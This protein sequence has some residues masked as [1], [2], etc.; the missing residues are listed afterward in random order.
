MK[1]IIALVLTLVMVASMA[2]VVSFAE[3]TAEELEVSAK[4]DHIE[5]WPATNGKTWFI[6]GISS[7]NNTA[8]FKLL[9]DGDGVLRIKITAENGTTYCIPHYFFDT[10]GREFGDN[11]TFLRIAVC[12]Y[13]IPVTVGAKYSVYLDVVVDGKIAYFG[14]SANLAFD[15]SK[16]AGFKADGPIIPNPVPHEYTETLPDAGTVQPAPFGTELTVQ[17][18]FGEVENWSGKTWF[19]TQVDSTK[20]S[21]LYGNLANG[22]WTADIIIKDETTDEARII[23]G[24]AFDDAGNEI[25]GTDFFRIAVCEYGIVPVVGHAY[26]LTMNVYEGTELIASGSTETGAFDNFNDAITADGPIVPGNPTHSSEIYNPTVVPTPTPT[27]TPVDPPVTADASVYM[28]V[29][30]VVAVLGMAVVVTKKVN[31]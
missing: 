30:A 6:V 17:P 12:D 22:T 8:L 2:A 13:G 19:I 27:P 11:D 3:D 5:N 25:Y 4:Y 20:N 26:T 29:V 14:Q 9:K 28:I 18:I 10:P 16:Q 7:E 1:K 21:K 15:G 23:K 31:A 24:Y